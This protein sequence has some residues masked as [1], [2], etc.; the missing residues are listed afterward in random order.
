MEMSDTQKI[1]SKSKIHI[2]WRVS[3][4]DYSKEKENTIIFQASKKYSIPKDRIKLI[5]EFIVLNKRGEEIS[6]A[7]EVVQNI[8]RPDFQLKLFKKY[9]LTNEITG[10]DFNFI[11]QIDSEINAQ[12]NYDVYDKYR[13][14]KL[15]WI[16]WKNFLSYGDDNFFDFSNLHGLVLLNGEPAN[17]S[18]KTTFAIDLTH[19]LF[20]GKIEKYPTQ[21]KIFNKHLNDA[22]EVMVEGC[23]EIDGVEYI[24]KRKLTRPSATRRSAKSKT[25]QKVEYYKVENGNLTELEDFVDNQQEENSIQTNKVIKEAIGNENDFDMIVCATSKNLDELIDKRDTERG[26]LLSRW[27]GLL[28]I[29]EKE[30]IAKEKFNREIKPYL[31]STKYNKE[32]LRHEIESFKVNI[33][34]LNGNISAAKDRVNTISA[35][36]EQLENM[37]KTL[38]TSKMSVDESLLKVDINTLETQ[39]KNIIEK[40]KIKK[41]ELDSVTNS[42]KEL[43]DV[44]FSIEEFNSLQTS[45]DNLVRSL[46][47]CKAKCMNLQKLIKD[48]QTSEYCPTCGKKYD[49]VDNSSKIAENMSILASEVEKGKKMKESLT[50]IE[51]RLEGLKKSQEQYLLKCRLEAQKGAVE[52]TVEQCRNSYIENSRILAE[53]KKNNEVIDRNNKLDIEIRN[54]EAILRGRRTEKENVLNN[55]NNLEHDIVA[56]EKCITER[57]EIIVN[58]EKEAVKIYNWKLYLEMIGKNGISKMV[59]RQVIP[60]INAQISS[61]LNEVCDFNV[62]M[63]ITDKNDVVF[64]LVKDGIKSDLAGGSGFERTAAA[65]A[66]RSV[67]GNISTLPRMS[68]LVLDEIWGRVAKENYDNLRKLLEEIGKAFDFILIISHLDEVKDFCN[69]IITVTKKDN[70]SRLKQTD[71]VVAK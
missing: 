53:Y 2:H 52:V 59:L 50:E 34:G 23:I 31:L 63:D 5:P 12:I 51:S 67:L 22:T 35:E 3:P 30:I 32:E 44:T 46:A 65:L 6:I 49:N 64:Y 29:E 37:Q 7:H 4:Y 48:L 38:L 47:D 14:Y 56:Y 13:K 10:Y 1:G 71:N 27:I 28:P 42:L 40:G 62:E 8:Q 24:I 20:F 61:L 54:N 33:H 11:S 55:I 69:T 41:E 45:R 21:D 36:I 58:L 68:C 70:V 66:L 60:V 9:L 15:K 17:Q 57:E 39:I 19:F 26:R 16:K 18:G 25:N 43:A